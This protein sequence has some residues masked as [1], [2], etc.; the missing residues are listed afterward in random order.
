MDIPMLSQRDD[1]L[2]LIVER[3]G[4]APVDFSEKMSLIKAEKMGGGAGVLLPLSFED[5]FVL[6]LIKRSSG[7][8]QPGDIGCPGGML[9]TFLDPLLRPFVVHILRGKA[10]KC[11]GKRKRDTFRNITLFLTSALREAWEEVRL[12]PLRVVFLGPLPC[13]DLTSRKTTIFPLAG[14]I[15][16]GWCFRPNREVE[17]IVDIP[18][19]AFLEDENY[20]LCILDAPIGIMERVNLKREYPC[21]MYH[22]EMLWGATFSVIMNFLKIVFDFRPP[23]AYSKRVV[24]KKLHSDYLTGRRKSLKG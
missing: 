12:N 9:N 2:D 16:N 4:R 6:Q 1:I 14:Y 19:R 13:R 17:K 7:V 21:F 23:Q 3:L 20:G 8:S 10:L 15:K 11:A 24:K 18:L 5:E 22:D